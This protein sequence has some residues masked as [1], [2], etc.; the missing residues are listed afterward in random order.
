[1]EAN[2]KAQEMFSFEKKK[3]DGKIGRCPKSTFNNGRSYFLENVICFL[4]TKSA[5]KT[6]V[7]R[8]SSFLHVVIK[9]KTQELDTT[10]WIISLCK[11][12][13]SCMYLHVISA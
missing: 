10:I 13:I 1:M 5:W 2:S 3:K 9:T 12:S 6:S 8:S 4:G 7:L 11:L